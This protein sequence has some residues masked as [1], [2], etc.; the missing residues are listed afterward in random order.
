M[1][2]IKIS[3]ILSIIL[4]LIFI[5]FPIFSSGVVSIIIGVSL[6]FFGIT[7]ILAGFTASNIIIG[8]LA[9]IFGLL[10]T[11]NI[12]AVSF[13]LGFQFYIIGIIMILAGIIGLVSDTQISKIASVLIIIMGIISFALTLALGVWIILTSVSA[14]RMSILVRKEDPNW[15]L[16][17]LLGI[18]DLIVGILILFNPFESAISVTI[19]AGIVLMVHSVINIVDMIIIKKNVKSL[20]K[21]IE[22]SMKQS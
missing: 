3:G 17:L 20:T 19:L 12:D 13:L 2:P 14:I 18:I 15:I 10:F 9:I 11:F 7:L 16:I 6:F 5:I 22:K 1:E 8:I 21:A 4:G